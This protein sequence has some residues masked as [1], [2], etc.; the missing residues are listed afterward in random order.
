MEFFDHTFANNDDFPSIGYM[1][2]MLF[3]TPAPATTTFVKV[4]MMQVEDMDGKSSSD[5]VSDFQLDLYVTNGTYASTCPSSFV[6]A[7]GTPD[8]NGDT[9]YCTRRSDI[10]RDVKKMIAYEALT[11][12]NFQGKCFFKRIRKRRITPQGVT[13]KF[14]YYRSQVPDWASSSGHTCA[15]TSYI[16]NKSAYCW[17]NND[18]GQLGD[19]TAHYR[20]SPVMVSGGGPGAVNQISAGGGH[21]CAT[22]G[23]GGAASCWGRNDHGQLGTGTTSNAKVPTGTGLNNVAIISAGSLHTCAV[24]TDNSLWCWG[25]NRYGQLG[26]GDV[27]DRLSPTQIAAGTSFSSVSAGEHHTCARRTNSSIYCWGLN[28]RGQSGSASGAVVLTPHQVGVNFN[29][30]SSGGVHSC[31][32]TTGNVAFCWGD[33]RFGQFGDGNVN[34]GSH[35]PTLVPSFLDVSTIHAGGIHTCARKTDGS[36]WC[37]GDNRFGQLG[38]GNVTNNY[39][40]Q[41]LNALGAVNSVS[42]GKNHHSCAVKTDGSVSCWGQNDNAQLGRNYISRYSNYVS[43]ITSLQNVIGISTGN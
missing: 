9:P 6:T 24:K 20:F 30:V 5:V 35:I 21:T 29:Q 11:G 25:S 40:P 8:A 33:N 4:V 3:A 7:C 13:L 15:I 17:G 38:I 36:V 18:Q 27:S 23:F 16:L 12:S 14:A 22:Y 37:W 2:R 32:V 1:G 42:V 34:D 26:T 31:G 10:S 39:S 28:D 19:G 43:T 41:Q